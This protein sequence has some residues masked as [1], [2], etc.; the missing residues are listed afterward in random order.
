MAFLTALNGIA[1]LLSA[2][3]NIAIVIFDFTKLAKYEEK[4][5]I[6]P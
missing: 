1:G 4:P 5:L 6:K 2:L 3:H